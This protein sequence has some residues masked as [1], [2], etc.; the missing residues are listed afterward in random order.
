MNAEELR[1][2][3]MNIDHTGMKKDISKARNNIA[4]KCLTNVNTN[5]NL[6][7]TGVYSNNA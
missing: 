6:M 5:E 2:A 4:Q 7:D 3:L 1:N